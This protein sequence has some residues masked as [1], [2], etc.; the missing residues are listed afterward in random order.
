MS[1]LTVP[2][3]AALI[4]RSPRLV[5][6]WI[7]TGELRPVRITTAD[8]MRVLEHEVVEVAER[9]RSAREQARLD[10]L[11]RRWERECASVHSG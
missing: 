7:D 4:G 10:R 3:A 9:L 6:K 1:T 8:R 2:E 11:T 5:Y